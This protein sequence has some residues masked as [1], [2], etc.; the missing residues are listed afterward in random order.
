MLFNEQLFG[1]LLPIAAG[2]GAGILG[3]VLFVKLIDLVYLPKEHN[4]ALHVVEYGSD[5]IK[6]FAVI[7]SV[8][9]V[10]FVV[11]RRILAGMKIAEALKLGED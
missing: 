11:I 8:V 7:L 2:S 6:I 10:C 4:I 9:L 5:L 3:T 1:S